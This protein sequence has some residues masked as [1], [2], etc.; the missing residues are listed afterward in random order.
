MSYPEL[1]NNR[2]IVNGIDLSIRFGLIM[3]DDYELSPPAYKSYQI[4]VPGSDSFIDLTS[5]VTGFPAYSNRSQVFN[6][7]VIYPENFEKTKTDLC[8]FLHGKDFDYVLTLDP[9]YTYHGRFSVD[10]YSKALDYGVIRIVIDAK[11]YKTKPPKTYRLN[12]AGGRMFSFVSGRKPVRPIMEV[13]T[14]TTVVLDGKEITVPVGSWRLNDVLFVEGDND[15]YINSFPMLDTLWSDL[16][17]DGKNMMTWDQASKY[18]WDELAR[19]NLNSGDVPQSWDDLS[20]KSWDSL[21]DKR[22]SDL[23]WRPSEIVSETVFLKYD[24]G[25]L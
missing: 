19:I 5:S 2:I 3:T 8:D 25:D 24:W 10:K 11:P 23:D 13:S 6:M 1:P 9:E 21:S 12:A 22:W 17:Q 16:G 7:V 4:D 18:R 15:I 20:L 14:P